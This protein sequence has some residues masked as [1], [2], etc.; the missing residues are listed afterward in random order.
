MW[1]YGFRAGTSVHG[2]QCNITIIPDF[3]PSRTDV[4]WLGGKGNIHVKCLIYIR[5]IICA[6]QSTV[7]LP[8]SSTATLRCYWSNWRFGGGMRANA[9][10][11][12]DKDHVGHASSG[13]TK[14][15]NWPGSLRSVG[16]FW[17]KT[18]DQGKWKKTY[19]SFWFHQVYI[20]LM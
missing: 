11:W 5:P 10:P 14:F 9:W 7:E 17:S 19:L 15:T 8:R 4:L 13:L 1:L 18:A 3:K 16:G 12:L 6:C 20:F 2:G